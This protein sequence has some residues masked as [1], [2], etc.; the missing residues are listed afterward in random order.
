MSY[1]IFT[2]CHIIVKRLS[3]NH[4]SIKD[5]MSADGNEIDIS[6]ICL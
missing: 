1:G 5:D 2:P 4:A 6:D 3:L